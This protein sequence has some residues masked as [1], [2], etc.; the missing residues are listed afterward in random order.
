[1]ITRINVKGTATD[2]GAAAFSAALAAAPCAMYWKPVYA[3]LTEETDSQTVPRRS[4]LYERLAVFIQTHA[5]V[6]SVS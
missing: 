1:M 3:G 2:V 4:V 6:H 5:R